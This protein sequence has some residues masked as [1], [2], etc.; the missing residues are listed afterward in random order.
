[1]DISLSIHNIL[2]KIIKNTPGLQHAMLTDSTGLTLA[3]VTRS[4]SILELEGIGALSM[5]LFIGMRQ[6]GNEVQLGP[7]DFVF[8]EFSVGKLILQSISED[9]ILVGVISQNANVQ[10]VKKGINRYTTEISDQIN[11]LRIAQ[12]V[13]ENISK[14]LL[15]DVLAELD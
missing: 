2:V 8:S 11:L 12:T 15:E 6:Q 10:K 14:S 3:N 7:L 13:E 1:M 4:S 9:C 5:A